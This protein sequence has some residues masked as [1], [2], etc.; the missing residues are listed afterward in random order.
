MIYAT[1]PKLDGVM[2]RP[3]TEGVD[4]L[5]KI[6]RRHPLL[7]FEEREELCRNLGKQ[8]TDAR[9][10]AEE[11][12]RLGWLT[13]FQVDCLFR[14][15]VEALFLDRYVLLEPLGAGG[16]G[17]VFK[18]R[19]LH[20]GRL[21][22]VKVIRPEFL[23]DADVI[24]RFYRE[25][26]AASRLAHPH[27]VQAHDGG[28]FGGTHVLVLEYVDGPDL[29]RLVTESGP[30]APN[31]A[32]QYVAQVALGLQH[33]HE[34]GLVHRDVKPSNLLLA[35]SGGEDSVKV[36]DLGLAR[37]LTFQKSSGPNLSL[38]G[39]TL[40]TVDYMAPEQ[41]L[42]FSS[43]D[44]RADIY[45][46]GCVLFYLLTGRPVFQARTLAERLLKHQQAEPTSV[47]LLRRDLPDETD[48]VL[49]R[50]LAKRPEDRFQ[51]AAEVAK[52]LEVLQTLSADSGQIQDHSRRPFHHALTA[53]L[54]VVAGASFLAAAGL[55]VWLSCGG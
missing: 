23:A 11:L 5:I 10:L 22:A 32:F 25:M 6:L 19:H 29:G 52:A 38:G 39:V 20:L 9:A 37:L 16:S 51:T 31:K 42:E 30:L 45:S 33:I 12:C 50:M 8:F 7:A 13:S 47:T 1:S 54:A 46:L 41:A 21:V 17:Q 26:R 49:A 55:L 36:L 18:A 27:I 43:A 35:Q 44:A 40:G 4:H 14:G 34:Q 3:G 24:A 53:G 28:P 2:D 48:A 15:R